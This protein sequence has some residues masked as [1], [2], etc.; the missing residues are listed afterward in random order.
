[1]VDSALLSHL[2]HEASAATAA[3]VAA[4]AVSAMVGIE[5]GVC[6][7][8]LLLDFGGMGALSF[9]FVCLDGSVTI[10][11]VM[12]L[13]PRVVPLQFSA[14]RCLKLVSSSLCPVSCM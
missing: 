8:F 6:L 2:V 9:F 3:A 11:G 13:F 14:I 12:Q 7:F 1:M 4:A 5:T 10:V